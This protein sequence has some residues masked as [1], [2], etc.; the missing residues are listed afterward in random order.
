M[1]IEALKLLNKFGYRNGTWLLH[2]AAS[3][4]FHPTILRLSCAMRGTPNY[5][6][7]ERISVKA[8]NKS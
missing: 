6:I 3:L 1:F 4:Y 5:N 8:V 2:R 7:D